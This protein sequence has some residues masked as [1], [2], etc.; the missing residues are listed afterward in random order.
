MLL[1]FLI[2]KQKENEKGN[3]GYS[4]QDLYYKLYIFTVQN[5][6]IAVSSNQPIRYSK[7]PFGYRFDRILSRDIS[8]YCSSCG[9]LRE[10]ERS[11]ITR[12]LTRSC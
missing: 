8:R 4:V 9:E 10:I 3:L 2:Y 7:F 5:R 12:P 1:R 11:H 6:R